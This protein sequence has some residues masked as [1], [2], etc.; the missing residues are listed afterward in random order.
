MKLSILLI[1]IL[2]CSAFG[3]LIPPIVTGNETPKEKRRI[4]KQLKAIEKQDYKRRAEAAKRRA[5]DKILPPADLDK[6]GLF[7]QNYVDQTLRFKFVIISGLENFSENGE[8]GYFAEIETKEKTYY[9]FP[10]GGNLSF[11]VMPN[12]AEQFYEAAKNH[13]IT[14]GTKIPAHITV[15]LKSVNL[16]N[17]RTAFI[18]GVKCIEIVSIIG[19]KFE[20][21]GE[22]Q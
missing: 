14:S 21:L 12:L 18:A 11:F 5:T 16:P 9:A 4:E 10:S 13:K 1:L 8:T 3:Q 17:G 7:P 22:C 19:V 20:K 6:I 2:A 15:L